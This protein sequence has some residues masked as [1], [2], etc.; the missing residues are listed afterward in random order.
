FLLLV[1]FSTISSQTIE[2]I[3]EFLASNSEILAAQWFLNL[4]SKYWPE[5]VSAEELP[6]LRPEVDLAFSRSTTPEEVPLLSSKSEQF[7]KLIAEKQE[8]L[9]KE[10]QE[11][12]ENVWPIMHSALGPVEKT[13]TDE[14]ITSLKATF[15]VFDA[16]FSV[17]L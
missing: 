11:F 4:L 7:E 15:A 10:S 17:S 1:A 13:T 9:N 8:G 16:N 3:D 5:F 6:G 2:E 12:I 14:F